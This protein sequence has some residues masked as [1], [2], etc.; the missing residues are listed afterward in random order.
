MDI[1]EWARRQQHLH[2]R[3][4]SGSFTLDEL[5]FED[6][7]WFTDSCMSWFS[8]GVEEGIDAAEDWAL[9]LHS[10]GYTRIKEVVWLIE[11]HRRSAIAAAA[12]ANRLCPGNIPSLRQASWSKVKAAIL[13]RDSYR[14][15]LCGST[16]RLEVDHIRPVSRGG[17]PDETN[18]RVLC[19]ACHK[20]RASGD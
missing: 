6:P 9:R 16:E 20:G 11:R 18:L 7:E 17:L 14:C 5:C 13:S 8:S 19:K 2:E 1:L 12:D 4:R 10:L 3:S 15:V